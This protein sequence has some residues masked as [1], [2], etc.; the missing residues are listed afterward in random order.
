MSKINLTLAPL[1][2]G[3]GSTVAAALVAALQNDAELASI[4]GTYG[5]WLSPVPE[6]QSMP[7][8]VV[9]LPPGNMARYTGGVA[10]RRTE[11][12]T[13]AIVGNSAIALRQAS[14]RIGGPQPPAGNGMF[15][16]Q[17][18]ALVVPGWSIAQIFAQE[19]GFRGERGKDA[20]GREVYSAWSQISVTAWPQ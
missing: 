13:L 18:G 4:L 20:Q 6:T 10:G 3:G 12:Y 2:A 17:P 19:Q 11:D 8:I 16:Q 15:E 1:L 7:F 14:A 5:V 9:T